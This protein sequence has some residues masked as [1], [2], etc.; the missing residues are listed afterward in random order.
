MGG[1]LAGTAVGAYMDKQRQELQKVL[2]PEVQAGNISVQAAANNA[3]KITM[4]SATAFDTNSSNV[5]PGF[6]ATMDKIAKVV[7]VYGKTTIAIVGHTDSQ[8]S[9][10]YN[11]TLSQKRA[12]AVAE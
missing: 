6:N 4:T 5:K 2:A 7:N 11:Q 12:E 9:D 1:G 10:E 3:I 8:G